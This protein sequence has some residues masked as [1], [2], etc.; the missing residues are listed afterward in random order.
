MILAALAASALDFSHEGATRE[1][2]R[3]Q[4]IADQLAT[5]LDLDMRQLWS[6]DATLLSRLS[7]SQLIDVLVEASGP[8]LGEPER[9]A[10]RQAEAK[11]SKPDLV[12]TVAAALVGTGWLPDV[13][14]TPAGRGAFALTQDACNAIAAE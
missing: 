7:K 8:D 12:Q 5:A 14:V 6:A 2:S 10:M 11:A 4:A 3:K 1:D 9:A 13:L